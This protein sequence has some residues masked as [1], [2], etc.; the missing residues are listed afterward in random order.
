M[1]APARGVPFC[2]PD[3]TDSEIQEVLDALRSGWITTG[4]KVKRFES[5]FAQAVGAP[6]AVAVSSCTA[7]LHLSLVTLGCGDGDEVITT[8]YTFT[9]S[10]AAIIQSGARPVVVDVEEDTLNIDPAA[11]ER[12]MT[13]RTR[14]ILPVHMAGHPAEMDRLTELAR[15]S[16]VAVLEDA[17]HSLPA[18]YRGRKIGTIGDLTC[19]SF[20]AT[21]N[22][23]TGEGGMVTGADPALRERV[24]LIG[25]H[26][27]S[28]DGWKRYRDEGAWY[29]QIEE[30]GFKYNM[31]DIAAA[32]GLAQLSR[33]E[34]MQAR[35]R[36]IVRRYDE[37]FADL[38]SLILPVTRPGVEHAWHLYIIRIRRSALGIDRDA[39]IQA[40]TDRGIGTS[41]HFIPL[42]RHGYY[43]RT[44]DLQAGQFPVAE[45]AFNTCISLP[46]FSSMTDD[47]V[48]QVTEAVRATVK[49]SLR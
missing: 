34:G 25:Y 46:L 12:A 47:E 44:L 14:A 16:G 10:A 21:K 17:A 37:A 27:M 35:R 9:S 2:R 19:F 18:A 36:E 40:L 41:V 22:L 5:A 29:Y 28:K 24:A 32:L 33:L 43:Q 49:E 45:R 13:P 39:F 38:E 20:Y 31:S 48:T 30:K 3:L 42:H 15:S 8:D 26:G 1:N 11:A 23:T 6:W 4:P 7:G